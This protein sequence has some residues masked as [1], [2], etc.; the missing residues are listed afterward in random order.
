MTTN[1]TTFRLFD[2]QALNTVDHY[3]DNENVEGRGTKNQDNKK[4]L[5]KM[6]GMDEKGKT[7]C[8][9]V[10]DFEPFFYILVPDNWKKID[11]LNFKSY[12][13]NELGEYYENSVTFC[14]LIK[15]KKLYG[16]DNFKDYNFVQLGFKNVSVLNKVKKLWYNETKN[17]KKRRLKKEGLLYNKQYLKLYESSLPPLLR[18]FHIQNISPSGWVCFKK[19]VKRK[20]LLIKI[21]FVIMS[22]R[23]II[24]ILNHYMIKSQVFL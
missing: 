17:F 21:H 22:M 12:I 16:F 1:K 8:V 5:V 3:Y 19:L 13:K 14:K 7:Y 15:R 24:K 9:F 2:F 18:Y 6:F 11:A 10:K 20:N 4:F 23:Q